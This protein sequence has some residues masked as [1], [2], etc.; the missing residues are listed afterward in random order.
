MFGYG[1]YTKTSGYDQ[2]IAQKTGFSLTTISLVLNNKHRARSITP[3]TKAIIRQAAREMDYRPNLFARS[4]RARRSYMVGLL[5]YDILDPYCAPI[6]KQ[7]EAQLIPHRYTVLISD[8]GYDKNR[9]RE[10]LDTLIERRVDGIICVANQL[11]FDM[12]D[13]HQTVGSTPLVLIGRRS[14]ETHIPYFVVSDELGGYMQ[15]NFLISRGHREIGFIWDDG[16][17]EWSVLRWKGVLKAMR[18]AGLTPDLVERAQDSSSDASYQAMR[19]LRE[20]RRPFTAVCAIDDQ[21]A[22]G[23]IRELFDAGL[24]VPEDVSV[25]GF[26]DLSISRYFNPTLTTIAQPLD[27]LG[28]LATEALV[29]LM[30]RRGEHRSSRTLRPTLVERRSTRAL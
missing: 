21:C 26:D 16:R 2:S 15:A 25:I 1:R 6:V 23:V 10:A 17:C 3:A 29:S 7:I 8:L 4:L 22:F 20:T 14:H 5:V 27:K 19:Q 13:L 12:V 28:Q 30:N 11:A 18:E 24:R 9:Y